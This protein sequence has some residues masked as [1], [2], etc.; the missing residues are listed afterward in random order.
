MTISLEEDRLK[1]LIS[2]AYKDGAKDILATLGLDDEEAAE[3]IKSLRDMVSALR[4][5]RSTAWRS[6]VDFLTKGVLV[7]IFSGLLY[8]AF[9]AKH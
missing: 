8:L 5:A 2:Q 6:F 7:V 9:I 3:D 1:E 4:T